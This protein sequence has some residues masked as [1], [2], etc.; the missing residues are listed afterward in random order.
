MQNW[1]ILLN[2]KKSDF[3]TI[4]GIALLFLSMIVLNVRLIFQVISNQTEEIGKMQLENICYELENKIIDSKK[5]IRQVAEDTEFLLANGASEAELTNFFIQE[6]RK[7]IDSFNGTCFNTY[8][9]NKTLTI[10]PDFDRP[11]TYKATERLWYTGAANNPG[12]IYITEPYIDAYTGNMCFTMSTILSDK[13]TV[14]ALDF[15]MEDIQKSILKMNANSNRTALIVGKDGMIIGYTDMNL[16]GENISKK[17][18]N[19]EKILQKVI[20]NTTHKSFVAEIDGNSY[21]IFS[22]ET[23]NG[24][25]LIV[26]IDDWTFYNESYR[27]VITTI[28]ISMVMLIV[29]VIFYLNGVKNRLETEKALRAKEDFLS[30]LST[31]LRTP[32]QKILHLSRVEVLNATTTPKEMA[33]QVR[34]SA[35]KLS[36][37]LDNLFSFSNIVS[38][39]SNSENYRKD[40]NT[41]EISNVSR[42]AR[43]GIIAVLIFAVV[44]SMFFCINSTI[45]WGDTKMNREVDNYEYQLSNWVER[46]RS[47]LG[48]CV[49]IILEHP[50]LMEDYP[51]AVKYLDEIAKKYPEISVC[52]LA[53]P[54]N[55][56][57]VI[58][59]NGWES[60]DPNWRVENRPWYIETE[61]SSSGFNVSAPYYDD[62]T[63]LYCVTFS[64]IVKDDNGEFLGIF[65]IDFFLDKLIHILDESYTSNSYAFLVD[66]DGIIISHPNQKYQMNTKTNT[67]IKN[68]EYAQVYSQEGE[69]FTLNDYKDMKMACLAKKNQI[70]NFTVVVADNWW[71]IYGTTFNLGILFAVLLIICITA[72]IVLIDHLLKWQQTINRKLQAAAQDAILA[73]NAKFQFFAQMS[74]EIRTPMNA[75]LGMN[76]LILRESNDKTILEYSENIQSAGKTLLT[77]INSIL[78]FSKIEN[79]QMK[80]VSARYETSTVIND[81]LSI[82]SERASKKGLQLNIDIDPNLPR[83]LFGDDI[84]IKQIITNLLTNAIKYTPEG[85]V[86]FSTK[87]VSIDTD[88]LEIL[89]SVKD[90][91]I[92]IKP[93]DIGKLSI[94]FTRLDEEKNRNIEGTGLGISIV[95]KLLTMMGSKLEVESEYGK[96]SNFFFKIR[97]K[98]I[99][100]NPIGNYREHDIEK[101]RAEKKTKTYFNAHDAKILVVDD[102]SMNL[103][104]IFGILKFNEVKPDLA[105]SGAECLKLAAK[106]HYDII[107]LDHMMPKMDGIETL[108]KLKAEHLAE[109]TTIIALTANAISGAREFYIKAG[110]DDYLSKPINPADLDEMLQKYL[111]SDLKNR[112]DEKISKV[113]KT[114]EVGEKIPAV[115]KIIEVV[116]ENSETVKESATVQ[117]IP[118]T[119][120]IP[121]VDENSEVEETAEDSFTNSE[122]KLLEKICPE[123]NLDAAMGYCMDSK[124]FFIEMV[125]EFF[126]GDKTEEVKKSYDAEDWKNYRILVHALKST[127]LVIGAENFSAQ[128][129]AQ[130]FAA[131]DE[132]IDELKKNHEEFIINYEKLLKEIGQWLKETANAKNI[133]S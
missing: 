53:N 10:I 66:K 11:E 16:I 39:D 118:A 63:G 80:I 20:G 72:V 88:S 98:I 59:N 37:M 50:E 123:I 95:Q 60:P 103:K 124:E 108:Q 51:S 87:I 119:E 78:D 61:R 73:G 64:Q 5:A 28:F 91:G 68:T 90:T 48:L 69:V 27:Q 19:Y 49:N 85:S 130:E 125:Q 102:N 133:D 45:N 47:I 12:K 58:M 127:S 4:T 126:N 86:T 89:I 56:H 44:I 23:S 100:K 30:S 101:I 31:E 99:D 14:V 131:K 106:N 13:E 115:E 70:S 111:P 52:Y 96:G 3:I 38:G 46:H 9:A 35:L 114:A 93:E 105:E 76:E 75:V 104:V 120:K 132:D 122:K 117:E 41:Q 84:R 71:D 92:G 34:E 36:D 116:K 67:E 6:K 55:E 29:I 82:A 54:Y 57:Q 22:N 26:R 77:L 97:Q 2:G 112:T 7:Q 83:T 42:A 1:K 24:W 74:H 109:G 18:T 17:L 43:F 79:G 113:E 81:L 121:E 110:F 15:T 65:A 62:Q 32:L 129:K 94:S 33:A 107:F 21:T 128:A 40:D 25:Y 8:M